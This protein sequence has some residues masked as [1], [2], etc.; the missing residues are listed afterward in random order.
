MVKVAVAGGSNGLGK[1]I[2]QALT[3][4]RS[5]QWVVL[6]RASSSTTQE[7][8]VG[9]DYSDVDGLQRVLESEEIHTVI[10]VIAIHG[11]AGGQAQLNLIEA[12]E[13]SKTTKRLIPSEFGPIYKP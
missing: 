13:R 5:H 6:S 4:D 11:D 8:A 10:S 2:V 3:K 12:A 7:S 1:S 9:V